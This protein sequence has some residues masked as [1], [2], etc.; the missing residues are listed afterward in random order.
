MDVDRV[1]PRLVI[2]ELKQ[3]GLS[4]TDVSEDCK[5]M[6]HEAWQSG[7]GSNTTGAYSPARHVA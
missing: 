2:A 7:T 5:R 3:D 6:V 4:P 1:M